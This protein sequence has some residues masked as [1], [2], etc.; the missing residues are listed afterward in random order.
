[1]KTKS[2]LIYGMIT[3]ISIVFA[4]LAF[5]ITSTV[6]PGVIALA[7]IAVVSGIVTLILQFKK[8]AFDQ[9]NTEL[10]S[11]ETLAASNSIPTIFEFSQRNIPRAWRFIVPSFAAALILVV[12]LATIYFANESSSHI[13]SGPSA[14][15]EQVQQDFYANEA[16]SET[17]YQ[18]QVTAQ[19]AIKDMLQVIADQNAQIGTI[20][21]SLSNIQTALMWAV[22]GVIGLL[23]LLIGVVATLG[24]VL[25][26]TQRHP[27]HIE[28][29]H[30]CIGSLP[31]E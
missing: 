3:G 14:S 1:M 22:G 13:T 6:S 25:I 7:G 26:R 30:G 9:Q 11:P 31:P 4:V 12:S 2:V 19:W 5:A 15:A 24:L 17:V 18:Q 27:R 20:T 29:P 23:T 10:N 28:G 21:V 16:N 8:P